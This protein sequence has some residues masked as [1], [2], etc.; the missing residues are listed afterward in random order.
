MDAPS[1]YCSIRST[2]FEKNGRYGNVIVRG[3][4]FTSGDHAEMTRSTA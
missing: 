3:H 1:T 2:T 4:I